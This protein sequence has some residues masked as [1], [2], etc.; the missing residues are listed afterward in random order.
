MR[1]SEGRQEGRE[2]DGEYPG[3]IEPGNAT[4]RQTGEEKQV[5]QD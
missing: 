4:A 2:G 5:A 1:R 3:D